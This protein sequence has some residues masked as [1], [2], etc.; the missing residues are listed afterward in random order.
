MTE[1]FCTHANTSH[2]SESCRGFVSGPERL[3]RCVCGDFADRHFCSECE[4][5]EFWSEE[6]ERAVPF[7][8]PRGP[9]K[10]DSQGR[11]RVVTNETKEEI[12]PLVPGGIEG[13]FQG[14]VYPVVIGLKSGPCALHY[15]GEGTTWKVREDWV[16]VEEPTKDGPPNKIEIPRENVAFIAAPFFLIE[17]PTK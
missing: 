5:H 16:Y 13:E 12:M 17:T 10:T 7:G 4:C 6:I 8:R 2:A 9:I 14:R 1:C 15:C 11:R 3:Y